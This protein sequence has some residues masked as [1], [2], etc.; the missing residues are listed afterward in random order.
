MDCQ[1]TSTSQAEHKGFILRG[2]GLSVNVWHCIGLS[3]VFLQLKDSLELFTKRREFL[4][5]SK[6]LSRHDKS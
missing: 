1:T 6:F 3:I 2:P 4:P 5:R